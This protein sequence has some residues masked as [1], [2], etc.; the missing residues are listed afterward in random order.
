[1]FDLYT[2]STNA[3]E[4]CNRPADRSHWSLV[5]SVQQRTTA[6][7]MGS[8][9]IDEVPVETNARRDRDGTDLPSVIARIGRKLAWRS[10]DTG[11]AESR[12]QPRGR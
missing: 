8:S 11:P 2:P 12:K 5:G 7:I 4:A 10:F 6:C 3:A 1:M 9:S